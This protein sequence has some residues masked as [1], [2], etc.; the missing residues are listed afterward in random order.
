MMV[1]GIVQKSGLNSKMVTGSVHAPSG[2]DDMN[3]A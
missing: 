3:V 1:D 2:G